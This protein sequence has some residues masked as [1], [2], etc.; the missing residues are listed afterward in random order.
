MRAA[1][2]YIFGWHPETRD[3]LADHGDPEQWEFIVVP[4]EQLPDRQKSIGLA[5]LRDLGESVRWDSLASTVEEMLA[6]RCPDTASVRGMTF[7]ERGEEGMWNDRA[8]TAAGA[9]T[10]L[11][12]N[13]RGQRLPTAR[14]AV[15]EA[16]SASGDIVAVLN[17]PETRAGNLVFASIGQGGTP[18]RFQRINAHTVELQPVSTNPEHEP[19][20]RADP[21]RARRRRTPKLSGSW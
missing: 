16:G 17:S 5:P 18:K 6:A 11:R 13:V 7:F 20:A 21:N 10:S 14:R 8:T 4:T 3:E 15:G 19:G 12:G 2:L 1:D 9:S